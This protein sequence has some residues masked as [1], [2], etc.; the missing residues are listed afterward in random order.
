MCKLSLL[1]HRGSGGINRGAGYFFREELVF[2]RK[3]KA[4]NLPLGGDFEFDF[5]GHVGGSLRPFLVVQQD[6]FRAMALSMQ[7]VDF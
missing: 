7:V 1:Y 6:R 3:E 2:E 5:A 4:W